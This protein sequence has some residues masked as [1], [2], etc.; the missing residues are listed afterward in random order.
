MRDE[1]LLGWLGTLHPDLEDR[2]DLGV[3]SAVVFTLDL[4]TLHAGNIPVF[5][6]LSKFPAIRRDLA[7]LVKR[8]IS[9]ETL[10]LCTRKAAGTLLQ[11]LVPFDVYEGKGIEPGKKKCRDRID[12]AR[13]ITHAQGC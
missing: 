13:S 6:P 8:E 7:I 9:V 11:G 5:Q 12:L 2:L 10:L 4:E 1:Q 3:A